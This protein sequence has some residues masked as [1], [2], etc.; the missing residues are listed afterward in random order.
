MRTRQNGVA[1]C[2]SIEGR[3]NHTDRRD[4]FRRDIIPAAAH[5]GVPVVQA[6]SKCTRS[7][8]CGCLL[9][10]ALSCPSSLPCPSSRP[11]PIASSQSS[12]LSHL[13][14]P[15]IILQR[16]RPRTLVGRLCQIPFLLQACIT[17]EVVISVPLGGL[18]RLYSS[19]C[20]SP[21]LARSRREYSTRCA[22]RPHFANLLRVLYV[23]SA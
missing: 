12:F 6:V 21:P 2:S 5:K 19:A 3:H 17:L 13:V 11:L 1:Y 10:T 15:T 14:Q 9:P 18:H 22:F 4:C 23:T 16:K 20:F 8:R 7:S